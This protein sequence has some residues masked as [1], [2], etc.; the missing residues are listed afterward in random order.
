M[1]KIVSRSPSIV[2]GT[3]LQLRQMFLWWHIAIIKRSVPNDADHAEL[4][5][6]ASGGSSHCWWNS[7]Q[8]VSHYA[9]YVPYV[10]RRMLKCTEKEKAEKGPLLTVDDVTRLIAL[11]IGTLQAFSSS[12]TDNLR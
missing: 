6:L 8:A 4:A 2:F 9:Q 10:L 7:V 1:T 5:C 3:V 12:K 11:T